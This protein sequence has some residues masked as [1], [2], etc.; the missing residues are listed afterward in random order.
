MFSL[1]L[2]II[3]IKVLGG[4]CFELKLFVCSTRKCLC[5]ISLSWSRY[6]KV[7]LNY[8][9]QISIL[10]QNILF[11]INLPS[12]IGRRSLIFVPIDFPPQNKD[13]GISYGPI[14]QSL[15]FG[16]LFSRQYHLHQGSGWFWFWDHFPSL[17]VM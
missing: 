17:L 8:K 15:V 14:A 9:F 11:I 6:V 1:V 4:S 12:T 13:F 3:F 16:V 2:S 7:R 5:L 10:I